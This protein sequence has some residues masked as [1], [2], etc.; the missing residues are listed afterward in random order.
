MNIAILGATGKFG[1]AFATKLLSIPDYHI[2]VISKSAEK[3]FEN[4]HRITAKSIDAANIKELK[5][6]I[7]DADLVYCAISGEDLPKI[8]ENLVE[9]DVNRLIFMSVVGIYNELDEGNGS[10][11]NLDNEA[12]QIPNRKSVD[13]IEESGLD[14]TILR[15]GYLIN[16]DEDEYEITKKGEAPKGYCS[17]IASVMKIALDIIKDPEL[18]S[19]ESISVTKDMTK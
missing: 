19:C 16:G 6:A 5:K 18:Y 15:C 4:S 14:Y 17:T 11:F 13:I 9:T 1:T 12:E 2:T 7:K 10:E 3:I 8:A